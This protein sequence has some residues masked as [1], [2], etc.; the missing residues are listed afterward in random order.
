MEPP[1]KK[2]D[3]SSPKMA[4]MPAVIPKA[5]IQSVRKFLNRML[6]FT[7]G[8]AC[9]NG[10]HLVMPDSLFFGK[11]IIAHAGIIV[12]GFYDPV[13][14]KLTVIPPVKREVIFFQFLRQRG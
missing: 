3:A 11:L 2:A 5:A 6:F 8:K 1:V 7:S 14:N 10:D 9:H 12:A 13:Q 4:Q